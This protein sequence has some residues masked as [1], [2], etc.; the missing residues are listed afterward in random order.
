MTKEEL[1][2][3]IKI[4]LGAVMVAPMLRKTVE[5]NKLTEYIMKDIEEYIKTNENN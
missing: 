5:L 3:K 2:H 4:S 1:Q